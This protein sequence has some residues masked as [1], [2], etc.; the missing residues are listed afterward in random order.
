MTH[1]ACVCVCVC[2]HARMRAHTHMRGVRVQGGACPG[3]PRHLPHARG[4]AGSPHV[5]LLT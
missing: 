5:H 1:T 2:V 4:C 3:V